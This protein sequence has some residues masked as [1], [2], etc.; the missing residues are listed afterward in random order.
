MGAIGLVLR[1][2]NLEFGHDRQDL[3]FLYLVHLT[4]SFRISKLCALFLKYVV[5]FVPNFVK[6][7]L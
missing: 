4:G 1:V 6:A 5:F 2:E 3:I 7:F